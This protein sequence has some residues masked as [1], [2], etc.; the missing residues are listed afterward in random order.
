MSSLP[1]CFGEPFKT[2]CKPCF[3]GKTALFVPTSSHNSG[4]ITHYVG[5][6][7]GHLVQIKG[8]LPTFHAYRDRFTFHGEAVPMIQIENGWGPF[9]PIAHD[10]R[11]AGKAIRGE[12]S[13][14][15]AEKPRAP[16][17]STLCLMPIGLLISISPMPP[18]AVHRSGLSDVRLYKVAVLLRYRRYHRTGCLCECLLLQFHQF[19]LCAHAS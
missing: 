14:P 8:T 15:H 2:Q 10:A 9:G 13:G 17:E 3:G 4:P 16:A 19:H 12:L 11:H 1:F 6:W 18:C 5:I 7:S